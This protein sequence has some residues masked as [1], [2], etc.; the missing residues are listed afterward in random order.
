MMV[1]PG[2]IASGPPEVGDE[3]ASHGVGAARH[4]D[5]D[6]RGRLHGGA[7]GHRDIGDNDVRLETDQFRSQCGQAVAPAQLVPPVDDEV[8][9]FDVTEVTKPLTKGLRR[10]RVWRIEVHQDTDAQRFPRLLLGFGGKRCSKAPRGES[11]NERHALELHMFT[12]SDGT[13]PE[14]MFRRHVPRHHL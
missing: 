10:V 4:H 13:S 5:R 11:Y 14:T 1:T 9:S 7:D 2:N 12:Q 8:L 6:G 3:P